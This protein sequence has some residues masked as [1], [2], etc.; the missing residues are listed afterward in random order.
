MNGPLMNQKK[1]DITCPVCGLKSIP[2]E[3]SQCPQC[4]AD[5]CC[6]RVLDSFPDKPIEQKSNLNTRNLIILISTLALF[7][8]L[9]SFL[10]SLR[11]QQPESQLSTP[12]SDIVELV[13]EIKT[14]LVYLEEKYT[15]LFETNAS[16][17]MAFDEMKLEIG[18]LTHFVE[19]LDIENDLSSASQ[20]ERINKDDLPLT[21]S[22]IESQKAKSFFD[23]LDFWIYEVN[24]QDT[25]WQIAEKHYGLGYYYPVLLEHNPH[26]GIYTIRRGTQIKVLKDVSLA[27]IIY[28]SIIHAEGNRIYWK[29]TIMQGDTLTSLA[30]RFS[31]PNTPLITNLDSDRILR[32]GE[33]IRIMLN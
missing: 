27:K 1:M 11:Y 3:K 30:H 7:I 9:I 10:I 29:Y 17:N 8:G 13:T 2:A 4:D 22:S 15:K 14:R 31:K 6:F 18:A 5:L 23:D 25:L 24:E 16:Q 28:P 26:V 20:H 32:P 19:Q 21:Q 12:Q 33:Q